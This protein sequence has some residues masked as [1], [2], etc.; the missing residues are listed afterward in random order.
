ME[1]IDIRKNTKCPKCQKDLYGHIWNVNNVLSFSSKY[2]RFHYNDGFYYYRNI[3]YKC[4]H[5]GVDCYIETHNSDIFVRK[6]VENEK[7]TWRVK[8]FSFF[9]AYIKTI[10]YLCKDMRNNNN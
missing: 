7:K 8:I 6:L 5:C 4:P 3:F 9:L 2:E 1:F 10:I